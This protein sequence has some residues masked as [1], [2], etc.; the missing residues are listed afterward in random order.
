MVVIVRKARKVKK[1]V[2][3]YQE[4]LPA[5]WLVGVSKLKGKLERAGVE[6][7]GSTLL[8]RPRRRKKPVQVAEL[9]LGVDII[10]APIHQLPPDADIILTHKELAAKAQEAVPN[11][12]VIPLS[13]FLVNPIYDEIVAKLVG[14]ESMPSQEGNR[15][16]QGN[17]P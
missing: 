10:N 5:S 13:Q 12:W 2:L 8:I 15:P 7:G 14:G 16:A 4:S 1:I 17:S 6:V 11:A 3:C 9:E